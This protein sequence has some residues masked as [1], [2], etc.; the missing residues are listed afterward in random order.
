[1]VPFPSSRVIDEISVTFLPQFLGA[2]LCAL[3]P[4]GA[5][6]YLGVSAMFVEDSSTKRRR[7]GSTPLRRS[8]KALLF[9]SSRSVAPSVFFVA[10]PELVAYGSTHRGERNP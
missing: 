4:S 1:M 3:C 5:L 6:A 7:L 2:L 9:S 10:P 8:L